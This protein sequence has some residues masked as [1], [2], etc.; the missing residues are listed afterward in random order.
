MAIRNILK[1]GDLTLRKKCK[2]IK[3]FN[4]ALSIL[5]DDMK[6]T[7]LKE[8]GAGLAAPQVGVLKRVAVINV[9]NCYFEMVNPIII[10]KSGKQTGQEGCLSIPGYWAKITRP[11]KVTVKCFDR[12][13]NEYILTA[14]DF[15]ARAICHE[16]D[17]LDG[18][19]FKDLEEKHQPVK[20]ILN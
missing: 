16:V 14:N 11:K 4:D 2:E 12:D 8:N 19:L 5:L 1:E 10:E 13:G 7:L 17:H 6:A 15:L 9:N 3:D 18:I 20:T